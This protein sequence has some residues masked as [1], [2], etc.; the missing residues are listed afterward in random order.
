MFGRKAY[1]AQRHM[2]D[3]AKARNV[4]RSIQGMEAQQRAWTWQFYGLQDKPEQQR[5]V[6]LALGRRDGGA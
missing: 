4:A 5:R 3:A 1:G 2:T 6:L